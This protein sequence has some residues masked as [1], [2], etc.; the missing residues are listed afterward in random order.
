MKKNVALSVALVSL[1]T[2]SC[3]ALGLGEERATTYTVTAD[4][5]QAPNLFKGGRVSVRGI[6]VGEITDVEP[7]EHH[8]T[9]TMEIDSD[10][11]VP[12]GAHL[13][14]IPI[15]VI[16]D[17]Y[18][19]LTPPY[20]GG[21]L[22][23]D[24][25]HIP[26]SDTTIPAELDEV[27]TQL[28]G[29]LES[30]EPPKDGGRGPLAKLITNLNSALEGHDDDLGGAIEKSAAVLDNLANSDQEIAG[31]IRN[32]DRLFVAL[33][34]RSSE[35]GVLNQRFRLVARS[36]LSDQAN[37]EGTIEGVAFLSDETAGL[38]EDSGDDLGNAFRR[39]TRV[40]EE[41]LSHQDALTDTM[42]W[43]N[44]I[45]QALGGV[46]PSGK[47]MYAYTGR[48]VPPG[49]PGA[50]YNY[51]LDQRD[52]I[53]CERIEVVYKTLIVFESN[54]T[55]DGTAKSLSSYFPKVYRDDVHFLLLELVKLCIPEFA[56]SSPVTGSDDVSPSEKALLR[57]AVRVLGK[58]KLERLIARWYLQG[59]T[60]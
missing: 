32:L 16:A 18:A 29:L 1:L 10:V 12:A 21:P 36:L 6:E 47:G 24:G 56:G 31:I 57:K 39:L 20:A 51:R 15:T 37:L 55:P 23:E 2:A 53:A 28:Q 26:L 60:S 33:A 27:V 38:I 3:S 43:T 41:L 40:V 8:V 7:S 58:A 5:E 34:D 48:Q 13:N 22:L 19:Q 44:V 9:L 50:E 59:E 49:S 42:R 14:I 46:D 11:A 4:V 45:A 25:D 17:R 30:V 54:V 35:I 52:T